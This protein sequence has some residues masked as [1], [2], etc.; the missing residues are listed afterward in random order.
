MARWIAEQCKGLAEA[1]SRIH[2]WQTFSGSSII[3]EEEYPSN[4]GYSA[5]E[6]APKHDTSTTGQEPKNYFGV[7]GDLK[8][9][10]ILWYPDPSQRFG[11]L[12]IT[13]FG[14][15]TF[16]KHYSRPGVM[17][18]SPSYRSPEFEVEE[19]HS[20][21]CDVWALGCIYLEFTT[22]FCGGKELLKDFGENRLEYDEK[23]DGIKSDKFFAIYYFSGGARDEKSKSQRLCC[24]GQYSNNS[25]IH[26]D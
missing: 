15:A 21:A 6:I 20:P 18:N 11:I 12:K 24:E 5:D 26:A 14:I 7:H 22:W 9:E 19:S 10:N 8:P 3:S 1:L 13:D 4:I 23:L 2:R 17:P 25:F 16:S